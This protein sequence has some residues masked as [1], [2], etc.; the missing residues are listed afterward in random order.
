MSTY[1]MSQAETLTGIK[2]H[3]LRI[4]EQ[5]YNFLTPMRTETNIRFYSDAQLRKLLNISILI[6]NGFRIS[7]VDKISEEEL[8]KLVENILAEPESISDEITAI[9]I[10]MI[11]LNETEFNSIYQRHINRKGLLRTVTEL[12]YP[13]L[14]H[15]GV[16]WGVNKLIP[17]QEH[18]ISNLIRQKIIAAID[19][20]PAPLE[21]AP[22]IILFLLEG[23]DHEIGLLLA[24]YI[25]HD[26]G[27][28]TYYLGQ[29]V[30]SENILEVVG[31]T[32]AQFLLS[33]FV[34][35][36]PKKTDVFLQHIME[37]SSIPMFVSG[38]AGNFIQKYTSDKIVY[39]NNPAELIAHLEPIIDRLKK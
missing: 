6:N 17:A 8:H 9:T 27:F 19:M 34:A 20:L 31:M 38:S 13:F 1:S 15:V 14:A 12:L 29:N 30:P 5:R 24:S 37:E 16:L 39:I 32:G 4:W 28:K 21:N 11:D 3:T 2:A 25:A 18:F 22:G 23:D 7:Q 26:L 35:P 33:M 10:S 36:R